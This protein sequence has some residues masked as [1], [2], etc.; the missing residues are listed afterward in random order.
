MAIR[1][2][3]MSN[4]GHP[5]AVSPRPLTIWPEKAVQIAAIVSVAAAAG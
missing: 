3:T 4:A 5:P 1:M 2:V